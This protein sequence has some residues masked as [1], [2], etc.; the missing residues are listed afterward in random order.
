MN[1]A[2]GTMLLGILVYA[3]GIGWLAYLDYRIKY[4]YNP[5][6]DSMNSKVAWAVFLTLVGLVL[7]S[8]GG[9][10]SLMS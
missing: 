7:A 8:I 10:M 6:N 9:A 2:S 3:G 1:S 5:D 4:Y